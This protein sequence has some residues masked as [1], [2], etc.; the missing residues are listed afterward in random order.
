LTTR[1]EKKLHPSDTLNEML[2]FKDED[3]EYFD[4]TS[5]DI[6]IK[7]PSGST[8]ETLDID[9][10]SQEDTGQWILAHDLP[11]DAE[12]GTWSYTVKAIYSGVTNSET[13]LFSVNPMPYGSLS[14]VRDLCGITDDNYDYS[15]QNCMDLAT[16][17][18]NDALTQKQTSS[19]DKIE[20]DTE[21]PPL[22][23]VPDI[24]HTVANYLASGIYLQRN[25]PEEKEHPF[26]TRATSLLGGYMSKRVNRENRELPK[27]I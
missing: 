24:I 1:T 15:L 6:T 21:S 7:T 27:L 3:D 14:V 10:L 11:S 26:I 19:E 2:Y 9:D 25:S 8:E 18:I 22:S 12:T 20:Y 23:S 16:A 13:F 5:I 4:P 17:E